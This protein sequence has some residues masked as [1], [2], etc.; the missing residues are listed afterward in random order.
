MEIY[1]NSHSLLQ[2]FVVSTSFKHYAVPCPPPQKWE[3][4]VHNDGN[5]LGH[6]PLHTLMPREPA[7]KER[8]RR[9]AGFCAPST[10]LLSH[11]HIALESSLPFPLEQ[12]A[13]GQPPPQVFFQRRGSLEGEAFHTLTRPAQLLSAGPGLPLPSRCQGSPLLRLEPRRLF[14]KQQPY[15]GG[16]GSCCC[17]CKKQLLLLQSR[18]NPQSGEADGRRLPRQPSRA[19]SR[20]RL[21]GERR[22][23]AAAAFE[24]LLG[25]LGEQRDADLPLLFEAAR[26]GDLE[27]PAAAAAQAG[28]LLVLQ[29]V[30]GAGCS[31]GRWLRGVGRRPRGSWWR[32]CRRFFGLFAGSQRFPPGARGGAA[33]AAGPTG[34]G[35]GGRAL[36]HLRGSQGR[37][38]PVG[39][40]RKQRG[41]LNC[42]LGTQAHLRRSTTPAVSRKT[43]EA[44]GPLMAPS[45][46]KRAAPGGEAALA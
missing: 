11:G 26:A 19:R 25:A 32:G 21:A 9:L 8:E 17:C 16:G 28:L 45:L 3:E 44:I 22:G 34:G 30:R 35:G 20:L 7:G 12:Q 6:N 15:A 43:V 14:P 24:E 36:S 23:R 13:E 39:R 42:R 18:R 31:E 1:C 10:E 41:A 29:R 46:Q 40:E 33:F 37:R 2:L 4:R 5:S 27:V 38:Y